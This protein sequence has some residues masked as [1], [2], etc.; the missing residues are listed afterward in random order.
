MK[1]ERPRIASSSSSLIHATRRPSEKVT[2]QTSTVSRKIF[3]YSYYGPYIVIIY[4]GERDK[5]EFEEKTIQSRISTEERRKQSSMFEEKIGKKREIFN[6]RFT[7]MCRNDSG[8]SHIEFQ[9]LCGKFA[10]TFHFGGN[11]THLYAYL[12]HIEFI[13]I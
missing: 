11:H 2:M 3:I 5:S 8:T 1:A 12:E 13:F 4:I 10:S 9:L 7:L 6:F